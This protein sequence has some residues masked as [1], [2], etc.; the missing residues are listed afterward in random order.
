[1]PSPAGNP[2]VGEEARRLEL[3]AAETAAEQV[4]V[5]GPADIPLRNQATL[6][7]PDR[8]WFVPAPEADRLLHAWGNPQ[9]ATNLVGLVTGSA[10]SDWTVVIRYI[11][12]GHVRDDEARSWNP[13]DLLAD[14]IK[15]TEASNQQ[16]VERGF[17]ALEI[18]GW[19]ERPSYQFA[20]H[21]L[22]WA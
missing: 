1:Q 19:L 5:R 2:A 7:L 22:V 11:G 10:G 18:V 3:K 12:D 14:L 9:Q 15:G 13:D 20:T 21:R 16:R 8:M 17:P 6:A 4:A